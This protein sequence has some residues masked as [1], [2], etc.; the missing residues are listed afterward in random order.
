MCASRRQLPS[1]LPAT[2]DDLFGLVWTTLAD[3][4]GT[5]ATATLLRRAAREA[6]L[7][8][9]ELQQVVIRREGLQYRYELPEAWHRTQQS[10]AVMALRALLRELGP[11]LVELTGSVVVTRLA[12]LEP[13]RDAGVLTIEET[14]AWL[15][16]HEHPNAT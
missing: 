8:E 5:A 7:E 9:P 6:A 15:N 4:M 11:I 3:I 13:L 2:A 10:H 16:A 12:Q 14:A 1:H